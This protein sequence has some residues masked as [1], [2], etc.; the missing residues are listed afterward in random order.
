[1]ADVLHDTAVLPVGP[2]T[3]KSGGAIAAYHRR[4][5]AVRSVHVVY[6]GGAEDEARAVHFME[7]YS[8]ALG[9]ALPAADCSIVLTHGQQLPTSLAA[10]LLQ[11]V[12][13]LCFNG[14]IGG[15]SEALRAGTP[16]VLSAAFARQTGDA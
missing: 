8:A 3:W 6:S 1:M 10:A 12:A 13:V 2:G 15:A 14:G 11:H 4:L 9:A 16:Q 7:A 5:V